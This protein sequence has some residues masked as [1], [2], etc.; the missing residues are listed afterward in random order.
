[1]NCLLRVEDLLLLLL[2]LCHKTSLWVTSQ[3]TPFFRKTRSR[4]RPFLAQVLLRPG[5]RCLGK[6]ATGSQETKAPGAG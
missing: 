4:G 2:L 3:A 5:C 1:M 6:F